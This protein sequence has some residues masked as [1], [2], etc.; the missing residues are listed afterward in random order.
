M[1]KVTIYLSIL[2]IFIVGCTDIQNLQLETQTGQ[3]DTA[4]VNPV[5]NENSG[6]DCKSINSQPQLWYF[7]SGSLVGYYVYIPAREFKHP[8]YEIGKDIADIER[9]R[10]SKNESVI[11]GEF[12]SYGQGLNQNINYLYC[13]DSSYHF[14]EYSANG[15][16]INIGF[17]TIKTIFSVNRTKERDETN[18]GYSPVE[19]AKLVTHECSISFAK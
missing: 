15:T 12:C 13:K 3:K 16:I 14:A 19:E 2:L 10:L 17:V 1:Y 6:L 9:Q 4:S 8:K 11:G 7:K 5:K 18:G